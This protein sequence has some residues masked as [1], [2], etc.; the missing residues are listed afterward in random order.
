MISEC[1]KVGKIP[2]KIPI[3]GKNVPLEILQDNDDC[4]HINKPESVQENETYELLRNFE[5]KKDHCILVRNLDLVLINEKKKKKK[6]EK[7]F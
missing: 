3:N 2:D 6:E 5:I 1:C 7:N 4:W